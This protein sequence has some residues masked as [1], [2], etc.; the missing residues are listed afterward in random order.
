MPNQNTC[1]S[2]LPGKTRKRAKLHFPSNAVLVH[3]LNSSSCLISYVFF[4]Y[5]D[6]YSRCCMTT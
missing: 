5:D 6:S 4:Y 1:A 2:A 3:C